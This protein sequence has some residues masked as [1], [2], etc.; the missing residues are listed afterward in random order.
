MDK[1]RDKRLA[2]EDTYFVAV[3]EDKAS[4]AGTEIG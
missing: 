2:A 1:K 3:E 4:A